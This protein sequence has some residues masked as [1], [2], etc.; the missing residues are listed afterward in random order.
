LVDRFGLRQELQSVGDKHCPPDRCKP[1]CALFDALASA[2]LLLRLEGES[3]LANR[4][5]LGWLLQISE[6]RAPQ[7]E[8]F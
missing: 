3:A 5:T 7:Q 4:M 6:G 2:L 1:H 8:L